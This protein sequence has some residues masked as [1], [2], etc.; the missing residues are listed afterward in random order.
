MRA[1]GKYS[2][3]T[4]AEDDSGFDQVLRSLPG[5]AVKPARHS[6]PSHR[7]HA[8]SQSPGLEH[9]HNRAHRLPSSH[10]SDTSK[11]S[12]RKWLFPL[13]SIGPDNTTRCEARPIERM[14]RPPSPRSW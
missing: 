2:G 13:K 8:F 12:P 14:S 11:I 4:H 7:A 6:E 9:H 3:L 10:R 1:F 5:W